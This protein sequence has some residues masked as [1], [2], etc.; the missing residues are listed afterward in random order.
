MALTDLNEDLDTSETGVDISPSVTAATRPDYILVDDELMSVSAGTSSLTVTRGAF[1]T[2]GATHSN[3]TAVYEVERVQQRD[4]SLLVYYIGDDGTQSL[5]SIVVAG[6]E[7]ENLPS[8]AL[9]ANGDIPVVESGAYVLKTPVVDLFA[10]DET[11]PGEGGVVYGVEGHVTE[12]G[13][14]TYTITIPVKAGQRL[15][16]IP[17]YTDTAFAAATSATLEAGVTGTLNGFMTGVNCKAQGAGNCHSG[18]GTLWGT[19]NEGI[20]NA[21]KGGYRFAADT[22]LVITIVTVGAGTT[23]RF[24]A[25]A[26]LTAPSDPIEATVT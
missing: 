9:A 4:S 5:K 26:L 12:A 25:I 16:E 24:R 11:T 10:E 1:G 22:N 23:G 14:H 6:D 18:A 20:L 13:A 15:L 3:G 17:W 2:T 8:P 19:S 21:G 7:V